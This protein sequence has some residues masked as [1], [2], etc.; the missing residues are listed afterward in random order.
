VS[1]SDPFSRLFRG[2]LNV[3]AAARDVIAG[4][5]PRSPLAVTL[6]DGYGFAGRMLVHGRALRDE[7][8]GAPN[9]ADPRWRNLM[10]A[11]R[12]IDADPIPRAVVRVRAGEA[13]HDFTA[14]DEGFF[15]GWMSCDALT[16]TDGDW[17]PVTA[18]LLMPG[19]PG[20]G[21]TARML[22]PE[23]SPAVIVISDIDDTVLQSRATSTLAAL[24]ILLLE[25]AHTRLPFPG[26]AAFYRALHRGPTG[27][28]RNPT[29]YVSSSPWNVYDVIREFLAIQGI[30]HGPI[31]LRDVDITRE[32]LSSRGHHTHKREAIRRVLNTYPD[33]PAV[34]V[35]D[36]GQQDP[37]IYRDVVHEFR[38]RIRAIYIRDV[39]G[40]PERTQAIHALSEEI[41]AAGSSLVLAPDTV[42][43]AS[44]AL[45]LGLIEP[46]ALDEIRA[47]RR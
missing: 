16:R 31:M 5:I 32:S 18:A 46:A 36:S 8:L 19:A 13:S 6:Y 34:L 26:V 45:E 15:E 35:G 14:D 25:N 9:Q 28:S 11:L 27:G 29:F 7:A 20:T 44:H 12:R 24:R 1:E 33:A 40:R 3:G 43:A 21:A 39:V 37:E 47:D 30:P 41:I 23:R 38:G 17:A 2:V 42:T 10:S 22:V 4:R